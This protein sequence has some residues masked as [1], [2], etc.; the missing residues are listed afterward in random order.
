MQ[1]KERPGKQKYMVLVIYD[2]IDNRRRQ[3]LAKLL[4]GY[5]YRIQKSAFEC[6]LTNR[7]Y[8]KL[9]DEIEKLKEDDDLIKVYKLHSDVEI[10]TYGDMKRVEED[11]IIFI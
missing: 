6:L 4:K 10:R 2:I 3:R 9:V 1:N 7:K 5:G 8:L 11:E